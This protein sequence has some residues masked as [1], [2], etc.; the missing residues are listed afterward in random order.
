VRLDLERLV[1]S[2]G[3]QFNL[4][5]NDGE[6][7]AKSQADLG[8][9]ILDYLD[10]YDRQ[11]GRPHRYIVQSWFAHPAADE[12]LPENN[13][14]TLTCLVRSV[15]QRVDQFRSRASQPAQRQ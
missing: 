3:L 13:L 8:R 5:V 2:R 15:I 12:V 11:G 7:G 1:K 10:L 14:D 9:A 4:V 6:A